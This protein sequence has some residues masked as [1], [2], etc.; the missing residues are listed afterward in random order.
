MKSSTISATLV[1]LASVASAAPS[2][3][4][5]EIP[6]ATEGC[7]RVL[8]FGE[9]D[10]YPKQNQSTWEVIPL[11]FEPYK[12]KNYHDI[13]Y[14]STPDDITCEFTG[15]ETEEKIWLE[16]NGGT[17]LAY[18]DPKQPLRSAACFKN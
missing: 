16:G 1:L 6:P 14:M 2:A 13:Y 17:A 10:A 7:G 8:L 12:I 9:T 11:G 5:H 3:T 18:V 4:Q 15:D